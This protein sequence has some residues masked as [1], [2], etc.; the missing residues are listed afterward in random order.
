MI[1]DTVK[2]GDNLTCSPYRCTDRTCRC[3]YSC[4]QNLRKKRIENKKMKMEMVIRLKTKKENRKDT[5]RK[6]HSATHVLQDEQ[7][8]PRALVRP[9][10]GKKDFR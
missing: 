4:K 8:K 9:N 6:K 10:A 5:K 3:T 1:N 7:V 2:N